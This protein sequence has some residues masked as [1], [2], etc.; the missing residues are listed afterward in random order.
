M[1]TVDL[2]SPSLPEFRKM[3]SMFRM[4]RESKPESA[5]YLPMTSEEWVEKHGVAM[6][7]RAP[8]PARMVKPKSQQCYWNAWVLFLMKHR[9]ITSPV[10]YCEGFVMLPD[11][12]IPV[13][14]GWC[15]DSKGR[16][17]DPSVEQDI[18]PVYI[19]VVFKDGFAMDAWGKL[20]KERRIGILGN[21]WVFKK[22]M[23]WVEQ[24]INLKRM[25]SLR[26]ASAD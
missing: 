25:E 24:G 18:P 4:L 3:M 9:T 15:L 21:V 10:S 17:L 14:H 19:G 2:S 26:I 12:P 7:Q 6:T 11:V 22:T 8:L 23:D 13:M 1:A 20:N 16:I 5:A